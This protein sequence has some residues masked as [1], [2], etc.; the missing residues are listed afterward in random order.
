MEISLNERIFRYVDILQE[1]SPTPVKLTAIQNSFCYQTPLTPCTD[2]MFVLSCYNILY[3][4]SLT[5]RL[6][7][8]NTLC[9]LAYDWML[10]ICQIYFQF[11]YY[12]KRNYWTKLYVL[13]VVFWLI[14]KLFISSRVRPVKRRTGDIISLEE[15]RKTMER[16]RRDSRHPFEHRIR[17]LSVIN[18]ECHTIDRN[19]QHAS[20]YILTD[21]DK[22]RES[23]LRS[24]KPL[25]LLKLTI[26]TLIIA[27]LIYYSCVLTT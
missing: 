2:S 25:L 13:F 3:S 9:S 18:Q 23:K 8:R 11:L 20:V 21:M 16:C 6:C 10:R 15:P 22:L 14:H 1:T 4:N 12:L 26:P 27:V 17:T 24:L 19:V 5:A 7:Q